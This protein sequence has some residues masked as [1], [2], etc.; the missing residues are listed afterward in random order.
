MK[1][2]EVNQAIS[3][4]YLQWFYPLSKAFLF[5]SQL[6]VSI[7]GPIFFPRL[8]SDNNMRGR[9]PSPHPLP[10][11]VLPQKGMSHLACSQRAASFFPL[12]SREQR[13]T[14]LVASNCQFDSK[15]NKILAD[16]RLNGFCCVF[17]FVSLRSDPRPQMVLEMTGAVKGRVMSSLS[18]AT[19]RCHGLT[20]VSWVER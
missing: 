5:F 6:Q 4:G 7:L 17:C 12:K 3:Q 19:V 20:W 14:A 10:S 2:E 16:H 15:A 11:H 1:I 13:Q 8:S 18:V 9:S